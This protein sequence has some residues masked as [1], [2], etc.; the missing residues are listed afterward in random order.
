MKIIGSLKVMTAAPSRRQLGAELHVPRHAGST[1]PVCHDA[2][3]CTM[4]VRE[5]VQRD[6]GP[7]A[8]RAHRLE[9]PPVARHRRVV[10]PPCVARCAPLEREPYAVALTP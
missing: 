6:D 4:R 7:N 9:P 3:S 10:E 8:A 5:V 1:A 2:F